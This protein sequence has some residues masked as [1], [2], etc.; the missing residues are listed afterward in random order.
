[1]H[2]SKIEI[3]NFRKLVAVRID[4]AADKTVFVGANNSGKTSAMTALRRFLV[5][6]KGFAITDFSLGHWRA[7]NALGTQWEAAF[8]T[9]DP[10]PSP[11]LG[12]QLPHLDIWLE[13]G[14]GE[15]HHVQKLLPSLDWTSGPLGIRLRFEPTNAANLQQEY[16]SLRARGVETLE[17][18]CQAGKAAPVVE[19]WPRTLVEFLERR[20]R[21]AFKVKAYILDPAHLIDPVSG[22][23]HPQV[24]KAAMEPLEGNP[25]EGLIRVDEISAQRGLGMAQPSR[26]GEEGGVEPRSGRRLSSQLR[27]YYD[28]HLDWQE[29]PG[30]SDLKALQALD[31]ARKTFDDR[32]DECFS[33]ALRELARLG[34]P[35]VSDPQLKIATRLRLQDGL[36]HD[37]AVQ[38]AIGDDE[39][40]EHRLP[41]D[42]NGLGYQNLVSMVFALMGFRD[43]WM[44]IGKAG[45]RATSTASPEPLHLVIVEEPEAYLHAQVQQVFIK[46][47]YEVLRNLPGL[48]ADTAF[49]TQ[50]LVSTHSSHVAHACDFAALRYFRR[51]PAPAGEAIPTAC[52]VNLTRVFGD[53]TDQTARF[54]TRYLKATHCDLFFAD[55]A[56][57]IEGA[58]ERI[59]VPHFVEERDEFEYLRSAYISWLEIGGSHAHRFKRL[60]E[61]LGLTTLVITDL[62]AKD[63][64]TG[65]AV[66]PRRGQGQEARNATLRDWSPGKISLDELLDL[67]EAEKEVRHPSGYGVRAAYQTPVA[68]TFPLRD[69]VECDAAAGDARAE[70]K[71]LLANTFEDA[72]LYANLSFFKA[73]ADA[74]TSATGLAGRFQDAVVEATSVEALAAKT[75]AAIEDAGK[76]EFALDLLFSEDV[77]TLTPPTYIRCGLE[78]LIAQLKRKEAELAPKAR[79][80]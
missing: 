27:S 23:A 10:L 80:V 17:A 3:G 46:H 4:L 54:V 18:A 78:W 35:G 73:R 50:L 22:V 71:E 11:D 34:Y 39:L 55:G 37:S 56:V 76:A 53:K 58:A 20:L 26:S 24:L 61:E 59:L 48:G 36:S 77:R 67:D 28:N 43:A 12:P 19:L 70:T 7:I 31:E 2:I 6:P 40:G 29:T 42:S 32:L 41:E 25:L 79:P 65:K 30:P 68:I 75:R 51:L 13:V 9:G 1:M 38:Y 21:T 47:A 57:F 60:V 44:K 33:T 69:H 45:A 72:V 8:A 74:G 66:A 62:D 63:P 52:V 15:M 14:K 16:L 64:L 49:T 5:D